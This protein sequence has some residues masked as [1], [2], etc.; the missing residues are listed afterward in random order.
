[1]KNWLV[2][3]LLEDRELFWTLWSL[4]PAAV[5]G[6]RGHGASVDPLQRRPVLL[7][8][9]EEQPSDRADVHRPLQPI[10]REYES[11]RWFIQTPS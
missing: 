6:Q 3:A 1:M 10:P 7:D 8:D 4:V 5:H 9:Q 2:A 11:T